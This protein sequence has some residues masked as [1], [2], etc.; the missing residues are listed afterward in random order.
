MSVEPGGLGVLQWC[1]G[2]LEGSCKPLARGSVDLRKAPLDDGRSP[3]MVR[4]TV[5]SNGDRDVGA[6]MT[7]VDKPIRKYS[8]LAEGRNGRQDSSKWVSAAFCPG[9]SPHPEVRRGG[10]SRAA[11]TASRL[12][13]GGSGAAPPTSR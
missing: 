1:R 5:T 9:P 10:T 11:R 12:L 3:G 6:N 8:F 4:G 7:E 13:T 2:C